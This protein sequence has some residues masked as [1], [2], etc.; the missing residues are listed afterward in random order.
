[1]DFR[2]DVLV[3]VALG[4][5]AGHGCDAKSSVNSP[6]GSSAA[7]DGASAE[8]RQDNAAQPAAASEGV[9]KAPA[10][11]TSEQIAKWNIREHESLE[12][13]ACAPNIK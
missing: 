1:M 9:A 8:P 6:A 4:I 13:L 2:R 7:A 12:L 11:P 3:I 5:L 10:K